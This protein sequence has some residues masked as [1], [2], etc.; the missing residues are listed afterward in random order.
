MAGLL[1]LN[2]YGVAIYESEYDR[3]GN[4][5]RRENYG[6][7]GRLTLNNYGWAI[8]EWEYDSAGNVVK[9]RTYD[10]QGRRVN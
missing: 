6:V 8:G 1:T 4:M 10:A 3:A 9:T 5:T 7:D 2:S